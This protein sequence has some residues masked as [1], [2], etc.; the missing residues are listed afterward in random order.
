M[1]ITP[2]GLSDWSVV[3][4]SGGVSLFD[5]S[6]FLPILLTVLITLIL[7]ALVTSAANYRLIFHPLGKL[8]RSLASLRESHEVNIYGVD[9]NDEL[10]ELS[11]MIQD[12]LTKANVD[13]LTG[14]YNRRFMENKLQQTISVLSRTNGLL[15]VLMIDID[16]FKI[17][18]DTYGHEQGDVCLKE[19]AH[20]L[21]GNVSR[22]S[23]FVARYG[24]EEFIVIL[25]NTEKEGACHIAE[26]LLE[27]VRELN[28]PHSGSSAAPYVTVSI[29]VTTARVEHGQTWG[30]YVKRADDALYMSKQNG[31]NMYTY[32]EAEL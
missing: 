18:N 28:I 21:S 11:K 14:I 2:I 16:F 3:I 4:L 22:A 6:Q 26:R 10:G 30:E 27:S 29:G 12:L 1:T 25:Q 31:R 8:G 15:S 17:Y 9:R 5:V 20:A 24:G 13:M 19:V 7:V 23:D 32:Y